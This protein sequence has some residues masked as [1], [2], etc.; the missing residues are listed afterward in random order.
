MERTF[1]LI[2]GTSVVN[3]IV[4]DDSFIEFIKNDYTDIIETTNMDPKPGTN[5][6]YDKETNTFSYPIIQTVEMLEEVTPT[7]EIEAP[8][9]D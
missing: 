4:A 6:V 3:S 2:R 9:N 7:P 5:A 8:V 1:A